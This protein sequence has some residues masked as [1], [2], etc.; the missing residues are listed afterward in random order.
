PGSH[1]AVVR[2]SVLH[3]TE[4]VLM[5]FRY[6]ENPPENDIFPP[7]AL[8]VS[9]EPSGYTENSSFPYTQ[10]NASICAAVPCA[11]LFQAH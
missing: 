1:E 11:G 5:F 3:R 7:A 2:K 8:Q 4:D 6:T 10:K 9:A